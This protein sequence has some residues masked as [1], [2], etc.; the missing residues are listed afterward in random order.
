M[1]RLVTAALLIFI[2]SAGFAAPGRITGMIVDPAGEPIQGATVTVRAR[3]VELERSVESDKKG[4]YTVQIVDATRQFDITVEKEGFLPIEE[5]IKPVV[6]GVLRKN[7]VLQSPAAS[8]AGPSEQEMA[9]LKSR[10]E[11]AKVYNQGAEA[12]D[13]G[14]LETAATKFSEAAEMQ[15]D[16]AVAWAALARV[17]LERSEW[18][19]ARMAAQKVHELSP[20]EPL[21]L[22]MEYDALL[23]AGKRT[24]ADE[25]LETMATEV[26]A[27]A[28]VLFYNRGIA[29]V[30]EKDWAAAKG[31]FTRTIETDP[32][33]AVAYLTI[34]QIE[35]NLQE[36]E[37][38]LAHAQHYLESNPDAPQALQV[39]FHAYR[40]LGDSEKADQAYAR[41][42]E[43]SPETLVK[44]LMMEGTGSFNN[45][46]TAA[47]KDLFERVLM[48]QPD[49]PKAHFMLGRTY[50]AM[51]DYAKAKAEFRRF[52]ELAPDDPE[53]EL[54][55]AMLEGL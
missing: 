47:A 37:A 10:N 32:S 45:G 9:H 50:T 42:S 21:G 14:E 26:P 52:L 54:A 1:R 39:V 44:T 19:S 2:A 30:K 13:K 38:A 24:E 23:G 36:Y 43:A 12:Y 34:S 25:V 16:L 41:L 49:H 35:V 11:A 46:D 29:A 18:E 20:G 22:R 27:T 6:G 8:T 17:E 33:I 51:G 7:F 31:D 5:P 3:D 40:G 28:A 4:R 48:A 55:K 15:P 53:A